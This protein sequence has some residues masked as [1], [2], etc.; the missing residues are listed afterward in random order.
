MC[1]PFLLW[2][3]KTKQL[4]QQIL[5]KK[6][7]KLIWVFFTRRQPIS[8]KVGKKQS[9]G[10]ECLELSRVLTL[11]KML[12]KMKKHRRKSYSLMEKK[13]N[14]HKKEMK[15]RYSTTSFALEN[16]LRM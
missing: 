6:T 9:I 12:P 13:W 1:I 11:M 14:S 2:V 15:T 16:S 7:S 4:R 10:K 5:M 3:L 8:T